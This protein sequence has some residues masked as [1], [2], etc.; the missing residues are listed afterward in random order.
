MPARDPSA[1]NLTPTHD[2]V[3]LN[4]EV[5]GASTKS[6]FSARL[7]VGGGGWWCLQSLNACLTR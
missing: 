4:P 6:L 3:P 2:L 7:C 5:C 1:H